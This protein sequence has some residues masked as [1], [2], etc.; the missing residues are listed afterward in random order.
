MEWCECVRILGAESSV[1]NMFYKI[2]RRV[3]TISKKDGSMP[4]PR[5][6]DRPITTVWS[7]ASNTTHIHWMTRLIASADQ[8]V[9]PCS[10]EVIP[11]LVTEL[12]NQK[13]CSL[14]LRTIWWWSYSQLHYQS[15][16]TWGPNPGTYS[17]IGLE[18]EKR[19][20]PEVWI[21]TTSVISA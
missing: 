21:V 7:V 8:P 5:E 18:K 17:T 12:T 16:A 11:N 20:K 10:L 9:A 19:I 3:A 1:K 13:E 15:W 14:A 4:E 6:C 2:M